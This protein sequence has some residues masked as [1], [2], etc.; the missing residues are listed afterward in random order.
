MA[1]GDLHVAL[2]LPAFIAGA[3]LYSKLPFDTQAAVM[4][5]GSVEHTTAYKA[6]LF[7]L[8]LWAI[9]ELGR[10]LKP[11]AVNGNYLS[12]INAERYRLS[13][14]AAL[15]GICSAFLY[16]VHGRWAYSSR[17]LDYLSEPD[18]ATGIQNSDA[19]YLMLALLTGAVVS[20][21]LS[22]QF[23][24]SFARDKWQR[25]LAGGLLMGYGTLMVPGGNAKLIVY[26]IP[27]FTIHAIAAYLAMIAGI[28]LVLGIQKSIYGEI[29]AVCC[30][31]DECRII[32]G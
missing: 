9:V 2:T 11:I 26:D 7:G 30:V 18:S 12:A 14:A 31:G 13:T 6:L 15:I 22:H 21:L 8:S 3:T 25:H 5:S 28:V 27:H 29:E 16:M 23:K 19:I 17:L 32:K 1:Q 24:V 20:A 10:I 4:H